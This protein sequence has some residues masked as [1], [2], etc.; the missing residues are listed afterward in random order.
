MPLV[1]TPVRF[2][3][4]VAC[5][6]LLTATFAFSQVGATGIDVVVRDP[7]DAFVSGA[8]IKIYNVSTG[9][10]ERQMTTGSNGETVATLLRPGTY[11]V[12]VTAA[13]FKRYEVI[14]EVRIGETVK[15]AAKLEI[16]TGNESITVE[17]APSLVNTES[18]TTG[19][20]ID[21]R[22]LEE[23]PLAS[24]NFLF[25]LTLSTGTAGEMPDVRASTRGNIDIN[26]N[27]GRTTNNAFSLEGINVNDLN[28]A[29]FDNVPLPNPDAVQEFK[30]ATSLYDAS[31]GSKGGGALGV[32]MKT[33]SKQWHGD[34]YWDHR[35][36]A[37]N[38]NE[39]FNK[40]SEALAGKPNDPGRLLQNVGG[41]SLGGPVPILKGF[42]FGNMQTV[43]ARNG[44]S[45]S[46]SVTSVITP[47]FP[48]NAD[49]TTSAA[50]LAGAGF[51]PS[52]SKVD[53]TALNILNLKNN[54]WF[55]TYAVPRLGQ[56]GCPTSATTTT[57]TCRFSRITP[58]RDD[59]YSM[60]YERGFRD[61]KDK[62]RLT[63]FWDNGNY[64]T[65]FGTAS[66]LAFPLANELRN[67]FASIGWNHQISNRQLNDFHFGFSRFN[68]VTGNPTDTVNLADVGATRPNISTVPGIYQITITGAFSM[69]TG[70]N[71]Q[72]GTVQNSFTVGD[73][74]SIAMGK[75]T[76]KAGG[77]VVRYEINRFNKFAL[78][79]SL[80]FD[81]FSN[82]VQ[83][84]INSEQSAVGDPQRYFRDTDYA[85]FFQDDWKLRPRLTVNLGLRWEGLGWAHD[86]KL[87]TSIIDPGQIIAN[88]P[89]ADPLLFPS[90]SAAPVTGTP[91]IGD[92]GVKNCLTKNWE[93]RVGFAW[94]VFG[95]A[96]M[97]VRGGAGLYYQRLSNQNLLQGALGAPYF[98]QIV[99]NNPQISDPTVT[100]A[101]PLATTPAAVAVATAFI[102][103]AS[104]F[105]GLRYVTGLGTN[106]S[107]C[108]TTAPAVLSVNDPCV[109]PIFV[110]DSGVKCANFGGSASNCSINLA[111]FSSVDPNAKAPYTEQWN[112]SVQRDLGHGWALEAA[113]V[114]TH[115]VGGLGIWDPYLPQL[116]SPTSPLTIKDMNGNSYAITTNTV[117]NAPL[118][119]QLLGLARKQGFRVDGNIGFSTYHSGQVT[120]SHRFAHGLYLQAGYTRSKNI[121]NVS[122]SQSTD[123]LNNTRAGQA[124]ANVLNNLAN[125]QQN[126]A[127]SDFDRPNR[128][129][130]SYSWDLPVPKSGIWGSQLFQGWTIAGLA[131]YQNGLPFSIT[132]S[133]S[134]RAFGGGTGTGLLVCRPVAEQI[135]TLPGCTPGTV[136]TVSQLLL[137]G[138]A[139][140]HP[141]NFMNPNFVS[142]A[143][144]VGPCTSQSPTRGAGVTNT[145]CAASNASAPTT[146]G[147][148]PR[149][150]FRG[151][152]QQDWDLSVIKHFKISER[153]SFQF[154]GDF[155]NLFNHPVLSTTPTSVAL[156]SPA[157]FT[158]FTNTAIPARIIQL[159]LKYSF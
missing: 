64:A 106:S 135:A 57:F 107:P 113:Y 159:G 84:I 73:T 76:F 30:T 52:A 99:N 70:V 91:G 151:P 7:S 14:V 112:L 150:A 111:S 98:V 144:V 147:N 103:Q 100:L 26:V 137:P 59:Q 90:A 92:C 38:A 87:R 25:L 12:E 71:D 4:V 58:I 20:P 54:Y 109:A 36:D 118:R 65:P 129:V 116:V 86:T 101:N 2:M 13:G 124:G 41:F 53:P 157:T 3:L 134:G 11:R 89:G 95:N 132:D 115:S 50:L 96:K 93:P 85:F 28:L 74:W 37:F 44:V 55:G 66:T 40:R 102:P 5:I 39:W 158:Q 120:L 48:T 56:S 148:V 47:V 123:E 60:S 97:V 156:S 153:H 18:A 45:T 139:G 72:R 104:H 79:G 152:F 9:V 43:R 51:A 133:F 117:N 31:Q 88:G 136:T 22:T 69:G 35:N 80:G 108:A 110:N 49:G 15:Q 121:D 154:R 142:V 10:L 146:Y 75:H 62:L 78:R 130:L 1:R 141:D 29:H 81:N 46:G 155:F 19:Q 122:G 21:S 145:T 24:P 131:Q 16:G 23:L 143:Q 126:R 140:G 114:G 8:S 105:A 42:I 61:N 32:I 17:A 83:G 138:S 63:W 82:F 149:N 34:A 27:G 125:Y 127:V 77:E 128:F 67:R 94:D 33:G 6:V 119:D 68:A